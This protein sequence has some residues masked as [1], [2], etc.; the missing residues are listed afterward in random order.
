VEALVNRF[1]SPT[2]VLRTPRLLK[3]VME[4]PHT[5]LN[6]Y[7]ILSMMLEL[8]KVDFSNIRKA[9]LPGKPFNNYWISDSAEINKVLDLIYG[10]GTEDNQAKI[11]VEVLNA[12]SYPGIAL[13]VSRKLRDSGFD[14]INYQ[15]CPTKSL[16]TIVVDRVGNLT[17]AQNIATVME[18]E[19]IFTRYDTK[20]MV[21]ISVYIGEDYKVK[22][23]EEYQ[24]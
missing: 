8:K 13:E 2:I 9:Q 24:Q 11:T 18:T 17:A 22:N 15:N 21:D 4:S 20:R 7:D 5:N 3:C 10:S 12:S 23:K 19:E 16:K 6:F 1:K 14:V